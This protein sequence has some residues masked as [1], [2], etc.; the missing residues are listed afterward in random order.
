MLEVPLVC[1]FGELRRSKT[2]PIIYDQG[3]WHSK[4]AKIAMRILITDSKVSDE[5]VD[6]YEVTKIVTDNQQNSA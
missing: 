4:S 6:L 2:R 5:R 1:E 3:I